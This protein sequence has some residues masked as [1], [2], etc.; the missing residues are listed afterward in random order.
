MANKKKSILWWVTVGLILTCVLTAVSAVVGGG[1]I[2]TATPTST[3]SV[4]T[5]AVQTFAYG[6]TATQQ[7][8][9]SP[10]ATYTPTE[11]PTATL[12]PS[13]TP[14]S[15]STSTAT[16]TPTHPVSESRK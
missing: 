10:T 8:F 14:T 3:Y 15:T 16:F 1:D 2:S 6:L 7:F 5:Q 12:T 4:E 9:V 13:F 11:T